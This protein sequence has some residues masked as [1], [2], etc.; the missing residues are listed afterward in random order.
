MTTGSAGRVQVGVGVAVVRDRKILL[1]ER[2]REPAK[3]QWAVPGGKVEFGETL[4]EAAAREVKEETGIEVE[5]GD[6]VWAGERIEG[7]IHIALVDFLGTHTGGEL[8][9][10]DDAA[11]ARWVDLDDAE[12]YPLTSTMYELISLLKEKA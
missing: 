9:A 12:Q 3:G 1:I 2:G 10:G 5:I 6:L 8:V 4:R 11:D 7:T